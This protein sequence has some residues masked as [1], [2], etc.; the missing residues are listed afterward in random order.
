[1]KPKLILNTKKHS[2]ANFREISANAQFDN[3][4]IQYCSISQDHSSETKLV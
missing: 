3:F 1:M 4:R 2:Q